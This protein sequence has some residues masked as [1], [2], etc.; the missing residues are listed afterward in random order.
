MPNQHRARISSTDYWKVR[1]L[2]NCDDSGEYYN[3]GNDLV[4]KGL[5]DMD[6]EV[7]IKWDSYNDKE[8]TWNIA[9]EPFITGDA[10]NI[11]DEAK[12]GLNEFINPL[13]W[14]TYW[15]HFTAPFDGN[16]IVEDNLGEK[17]HEF[18]WIYSNNCDNLVLEKIGQGYVSVPSQEGVELYIAWS[19]GDASG[20]NWNLEYSEAQPGQFCSS[21]ATAVAGENYTPTPYHYYF[22]NYWFTYTVP[23]SGEY[24]IS[25]PNTTTNL[26]VFNGCNGDNLLEYFTDDPR[27]VTLLFNAN[28]EIKFYWWYDKN[29][30]PPFPNQFYWTIEP[31]E[32]YACSKPS[33]ALI[34]S[35]TTPGTPFWFQFNS[36]SDGAYTITSEYDYSSLTVLNEC[37]GDTILVHNGSDAINIDLNTNDEIKLLWQQDGGGNTTSFNWTMDL[38][39]GI[40]EHPTEQP[41]F[42]PNPADDFVYLKLTGESM[43]DV[44]I[45]IVDAAGRVVYS[46]EECSVNCTYLEL[47]VSDLTNGLYILNIYSDYAKTYAKKILIQHD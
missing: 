26:S 37:E 35:N 46:L 43:V 2:Y 15:Y 42:Y 23:Q 19:T 30:I 31:P 6:L 39:T 3:D 45:E 34:G 11:A 14:A 9:V 27:D 7:I 20:W 44:K 18:V 21:P 12:I 32:G 28:D 38:P 1:F 8:I 22:T 25:F 40:V 29:D 13:R 36:Q 4:I 16:L 47:S 33:S 5:A 41:I 17:W 24:T 10:C